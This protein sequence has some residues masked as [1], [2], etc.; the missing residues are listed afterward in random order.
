MDDLASIA[1]PATDAATIQGILRLR[2]RSSPDAPAVSFLSYP[3]GQEQ[4]E[5]LSYARLDRRAGAVAAALL[6]RAAPGDRV[7]LA[8]EPGLAFVEAFFGCLYAG[9]VAIPVAPPR[10]RDQARLDRIAQDAGARLLLLTHDQIS[11][12]TGSRIPGPSILASESLAE[13]GGHAV[14]SPDE[15]NPLAHLQYTSGTTGNPK[16]VMVRQRALLANLDQLRRAYEL[17]PSSAGVNWLP[18]YHDMGLVATLLLPIYIGAATTLM[19]PL[20]FVQRPERWLAA[21]GRYGGTVC[22]GP[23]FAYQHCVDRVPETLRGTF[24]L[25]R[26]RI[27]FCGA[28]MVHAAALDRFAEAFAPSGFLPAGFRPGYGLAEAT[29]FLSGARS[30][31]GVRAVDFDAAAL[32]RGEVRPADRVTP[33]RRLVGC[34]VPASDTEIR[35]VDDRGEEAGAGRVGEIWASGPGL[36]SGY[37]GREDETRE[38]FGATLPQAPGRAFLRTGDLGFLHGGEL[39]IS[40]RSKDLIIVDG[41]NVAPQDL[42]WTAQASHPAIVQAAAFAVTLDGVERPVMIAEIERR[43][44]PPDLDAVGAAIRRAVSAAHD[45]PLAALGLVR[46]GLLARTTSGKLARGA[47]RR[48]YLDGGLPMLH[49]WQDRAAAPAD[50]PSALPA[51]PW[52]VRPRIHPAPALRLYCFPYGGGGASAY[53]AWARHLD[54]RIELCAVQLPGRE[55]RL[56]EEPIRRIDPLCKAFEGLAAMQ[57]DMPFAFFGYCLGGRTAFAVA[58]HLRRKGLAQPCALILAATQEPGRVPTPEPPPYRLGDPEFLDYVSGM[59]E[60]P[61]T[62]R[63][64]PEALRRVLHV[65]R[66]DSELNESLPFPPEPPLDCPIT[67]LGGLDDQVVGFDDLAAWR[68]HTAGAFTLQMLDG[69]HLFLEEQRA[70][71][72]RRISHQLAPFGRAGDED[73]S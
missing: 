66:A 28:E 68:R 64:N 41:R 59:I 69:G 13:E 70:A 62:I 31:Q 23:S 32:E 43:G 30:G 55:T 63:G 12:W 35:I 52:L 11:R 71:I 1:G 20:T 49:R 45:V 56:A 46:P 60:V 61:A 36:A 27:A 53:T 18:L 24:D 6:K 14:V 54:P 51:T 19:S 50:G 34:G 65:F 4:L 22:G 57:G 67:V 38:T 39:F 8:H 40:G 44:G 42:E 9:M 58:R 16:G 72:L 15:E 5:T 48:A 2:G 37:W 10:P 21:V 7:I 26:W 33:A 3:D 73:P 25:S 29:L 17:G 47:C